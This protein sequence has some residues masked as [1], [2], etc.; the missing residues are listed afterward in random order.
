MLRY[1][2]VLPGED[3]NRAVGNIYNI[4]ANQ[5]SGHI[6]IGDAANLCTSSP[7]VAVRGM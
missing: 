2:L 6:V 1:Y 7:D 3:A 4:T 5:C